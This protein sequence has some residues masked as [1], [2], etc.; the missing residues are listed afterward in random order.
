MGA[1]SCYPKLHTI[2]FDSN[3]NTR[4]LRY[5]SSQCHPNKPHHLNVIQGYFG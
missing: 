5:L 2:H 3:R 1:I 4:I